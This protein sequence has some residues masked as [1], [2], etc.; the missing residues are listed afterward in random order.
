[1]NVG[2]VE[3]HDART[4]LP[5]GDKQPRQGGFAGC[6][7]ADDRNGLAG[8]G[9]E[10][11]VVQ[12]RHLGTRRRERDILDIEL[13]LRRRQRHA[14]LRQRRRREEA[15]QPIAGGAV[16]HNLLPRA[17]RLL[18]RSERSTHDDR[19]ADHRPA[20]DHLV[21]RQY[22]SD[23]EDGDLEQQPYGFGD[24]DHDGRPAA[25]RKVKVDDLAIARH[26]LVGDAAGH[27]HGGD[28]LR[29]AHHHLGSAHAA[30]PLHVG[31]AQGR[32]G[33]VFVQPG[34]GDED[35]AAEK[36]HSSQPGVQQKHHREINGRPKR[37]EQGEECGASEK[38]A[39]GRKVL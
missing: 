38:A 8:L 19:G 30:E 39:Y 24:R 14:L 29:I 26:P 17:D 31:C 32:T 23:A 21:D 7:R 1:V 20:R 27:A 37:V 25:R 2:P 35:Q 4:R 5:G 22:R 11:Y 33:D 36:A 10:G 34:Q 6:R 28:R 13:P 12:H 16:V 9:G 15:H 3:P 18:D